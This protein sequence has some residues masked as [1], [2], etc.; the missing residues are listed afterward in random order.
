MPKRRLNAVAKSP[1]RLKPMSSAIHWIWRSPPASQAAPLPANEF[2]ARARWTPRLGAIWSINPRNQLKL[3][4]GEAQQD[5][6]QVEVSEAET[7]A[8]W[9]LNYLSRFE[10]GSLQLS[11]FENRTDHLL[12][13]TQFLNPA[14]G[15][16]EKLIDNSG[17]L[18]TRGVELI[19]RLRPMRGL[20]WSFSASWQDTDDLENTGIAPG[21]SPH[22]LLKSQLSYCRADW[23]GGLS[24]NYVGSMKADWQWVD[25]DQPG[26]SARI[27]DSVDSYLLVDANLRYDFPGRGPYANLHLGNLL[28]TDIRYPANELVD[29]QHGAPGPGRQLLLTLGWKF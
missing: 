7:I 27:G 19:A 26:V 21:Y 17:R 6:G 29:F 9:E 14:T 20:D 4:Y 25:G 1:V 18:R 28:D 22:W 24:L 15:R 10:R 23:T 16:Y 13:K 2:P 11:L 3:L 5:N 12:R 8:T